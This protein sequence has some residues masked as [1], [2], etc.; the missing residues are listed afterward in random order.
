MQ[1]LALHILLAILVVPCST[2]LRAAEQWRINSTE[3]WK[4]SRSQSDGLTFE[5][6]FALPLGKAGSYR[7]VMRRFDD[8][9][10]ASHIVVEQSP[11]WLNWNA[12]EPIGPTN[13]VDAPV[14]LTLGPGDYWLFGRYGR[15]TGDTTF[16]SE[17]A[18]LE[19]FD[20]PLRTTPFKNQ[21]DAAG[22]L[23]PGLGGYHA[24]QSKDMVHWVHH[25]P[26]TE[27]F[28]RWVTTAEYVDGKAYVYYD[29]PNDQDP[30]LYIDENLTDG[31][32]GKNMGLAFDDPSDGSDCAVIRDLEG[33]FH[34][35]YEDW[36]PINAG[37]HSWDSPLA[38]HAV[39]ANGI[40]HFRI[41]K[42]AVDHRTEPTGKFAEYRHPHWT[43]H[44]HWN[45]NIATYEVHEPEQNAY[46][47]WAAIGIGG[48][49]YLFGDFHAAG[50][51]GE[52]MSVAWFTS[53]SLDAPFEY[54]GQIGNGHPDP[55]IAFAEGQFYLVTQTDTDFVSP[56]PWVQRVEIRVGVDRN[57]DGQIDVWTKW[58]EVK[59]SYAPIKGFSKQVERIPASMELTDLPAGFG[60]CFE[61]RTT[62]TTGNLS[63]PTLDS[64][65]MFFE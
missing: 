55:D 64:I 46:G 31:V 32:P 28:S 6:G 14:L 42:P 63:A 44:P 26:V 29:Y 57:G 27:A 5:E 51:G 24:W 43:Q 65:S 58:Q 23:K 56:G 15:S 49:Y 20:I 7:S 4:Q 38:G 21:F 10:S 35:I 12:V 33:R 1:P 61:F 11:V 18:K 50:N 16:T 62:D 3:E 53:S 17:E 9:T 22:G 13:L 25:G 54:C 40:D 2:Q 34:V 41:L 19:G 60:F 8:K 48:Q 45:S 47:D 30:H 37:N 39:S 52:E 59:E 36:S